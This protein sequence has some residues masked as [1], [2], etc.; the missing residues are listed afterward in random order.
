MARQGRLEDGAAHSV[1][2]YV[3]PTESFPRYVAAA[4]SVGADCARPISQ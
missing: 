1:R 2:N 3:R 4:G